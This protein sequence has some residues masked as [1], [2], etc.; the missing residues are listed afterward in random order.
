MIDHLKSSA[1]G[2]EVADGLVE[3]S[4]TWESK[5]NIKLQSLPQNRPRPKRIL[6]YF[7]VSIDMHLLP[8]D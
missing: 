1:T 6:P 5:R 7:Q 2:F 4:T 3:T 8:K